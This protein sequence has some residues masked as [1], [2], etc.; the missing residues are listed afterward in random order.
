MDE[1]DVEIYLEHSLIPLA[2]TICSL[3]T[4]LQI[5]GLR[6]SDEIR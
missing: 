3:K 2:D 4:L 6:E 1:K 5:L